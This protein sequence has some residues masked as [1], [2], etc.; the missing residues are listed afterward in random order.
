MFKY[1]F[2]YFAFSVSLC[3]LPNMDDSDDNDNDNIY[4][5]KRLSILI[6]PDAFVWVCVTIDDASCPRKRMSLMIIERWHAAW[7]KHTKKTIIY[8]C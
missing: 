5:L 1:R 4:K 6:L 3:S 7:K 8:C 2:A